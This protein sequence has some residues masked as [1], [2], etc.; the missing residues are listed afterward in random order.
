MTWTVR[1]KNKFSLVFS[2]FG[3]PSFSPLSLSLSMLFAFLFLFL[4]I[5]F[6]SFWSIT[7]Y[8]FLRW[9]KLKCKRFLVWRFSSWEG[10]EK[11]EWMMERRAGANT[12]RRKSVP[13][14][15]FSLS[16]WEKERKFRKRVREEKEGGEDWTLI[17]ELY[18][19]KSG[20]KQKREKRRRERKMEK[21]KLLLLTSCS[22]KLSQIHNRGTFSLFL[23]LSFL[24]SHY[25]L[26]K[27][28]SKRE[29]EK[30]RR[31]RNA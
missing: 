1:G 8:G 4:Y 22:G 17:Y 15:S 24:L 18:D 30:E 3:L 20:K 27:K 13:S 25:F 29:K 23:S 11:D 31:T 9:K 16:V 7:K 5:S 19:W 14:L 21:E 28:E 6:P 26:K 10:E 12:C 2:W